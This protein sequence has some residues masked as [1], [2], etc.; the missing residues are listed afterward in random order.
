MPP[1]EGLGIAVYRPAWEAGD[2]H[3]LIGLLDP[4]TI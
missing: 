2:I 4:D 1:D 3:A